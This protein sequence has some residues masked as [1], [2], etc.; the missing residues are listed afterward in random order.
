MIRGDVRYHR[1]TNAEDVSALLLESGPDAVLIGGG[2]IVVPQLTRNERRASDVVDLRGLG[3]DRIVVDDGFVD[4]G[5][6]VTYSTVLRADSLPGA[7]S[8]LQKLADVVTGGSQIRNLGTLGGSAAYANPSSDVP[9]ALVALGAEMKIAGPDGQRE[10]SAGDF[11]LDAHKTALGPAELLL[12]M[13]IP[14]SIA[15]TGYIKIKAA[16]S[17]WPVVTAS[18]V[19]SATDAHVTIGAAQSVPIRIGISAFRDGDRWETDGLMAA[20]RS[21]I[22]DPWHDSQ[23][24]ASYRKHVAGVMARRAVERSAS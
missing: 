9:G 7:T 1:P 18:A 12:G 15:S 19:V 24:T 20:V 17:G 10:V 22:T 2:T 14:T 16:S 13:R 3:I 6:M 5:A 11:F 4:I 23:A 21:A 8:L